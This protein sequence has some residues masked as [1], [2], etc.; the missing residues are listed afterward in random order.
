MKKTRNLRILITLLL[1]VFCI[2]GFV[3]T[4]SNA[5]NWSTQINNL[6][7]SN[8][9]TNV[10]NKVTNVVGAAIS[11]IRIIGTGVA[12]IMLVAIAIKY[13]SAAPGERAEIKKHAVPYVV[14]A[15]VLFASTNI[16]KIIQDFSQN[17]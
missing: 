8:G 7:K 10:N 11:V 16:L 15:I 2:L 5:Y 4:V 3:S 12:I 9:Y 6:D 13:M 17:I 1:V 14:G